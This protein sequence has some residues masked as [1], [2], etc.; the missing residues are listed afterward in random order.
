MPLIEVGNTIDG[1]YFL[2]KNI[3]RSVLH[4]PVKHPG[5]NVKSAIRYSG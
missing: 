2:G 3:M 4:I 1:E 5:R